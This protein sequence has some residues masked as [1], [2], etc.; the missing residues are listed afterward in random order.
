MVCKHKKNKKL[1]VYYDPNDQDSKVF[2][3]RSTEVNSDNSMFTRKVA[4]KQYFLRDKSGKLLGEAQFLEKSIDN[5]EYK[6]FIETFKL[7]LKNDVVPEQYNVTSM[8]VTPRPLFKSLE[9][10]HTLGKS[11][12]NHLDWEFP[13]AE[14]PSQKRKLIFSKKED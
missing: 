9:L 14:N 3:S 5:T 12:F 2:I 6:I 10:T 7:I 8:A 11:S 1:V 4:E 13:S